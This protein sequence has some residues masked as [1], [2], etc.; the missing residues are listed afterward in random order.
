MASSSLCGISGWGA[1]EHQHGKHIDNEPTARLCNDEQS[2]HCRKTTPKMSEDAT[3]LEITSPPETKSSPVEKTFRVSPLIR[4]TLLLLYVALTLPLPSLATV[5]Q[6][7][8]SPTLLWGAITL[9]GIL[10]YGSLSEQVHVDQSGIQAGHPRWISWLLQRRWELK[11][12]D[13]T[14]LKPRTTGQGGLVYYFTS[15]TAERA[16]LLPMRVAGFAE[17][18]RYIESHTQL[19]TRD[20]KPLAQPWMYFI[21]LGFSSLL[22]LID[23]WTL[24]TAS[25]WMG[26]A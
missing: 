25:H 14:A 10:V 5:T 8:V 18:L 2:R 12:D 19:D 24:W 15:H 16:F 9:G 6:A 26:A 17:L 20:V 7:P 11:W 22:L 4:I 3:S 13:I 23:F 21:L 1:N